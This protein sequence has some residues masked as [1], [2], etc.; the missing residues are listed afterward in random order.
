METWRRALAERAAY[1]LSAAV[2]SSQWRAFCGDALSNAPLTPALPLTSDSHPSSPP[3][4]VGWWVVRAKMRNNCVSKPAPVHTPSQCWPL[5]PAKP[6]RHHVSTGSFPW[7][8]CTWP[9]CLAWGSGRGP[10]CGPCSHA[11]PLLLEGGMEEPFLHT[12]AGGR[13]GSETPRRC[14]TSL[15]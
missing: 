15:P 3:Q 4:P 7:P 14:G 13:E 1:L 5:K 6:V 9:C 8:G 2:P 12:T 11:R 10:Q